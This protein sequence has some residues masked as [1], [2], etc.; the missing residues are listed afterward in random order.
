MQLKTVVQDITTVP[1]AVRD[2]YKQ[3]GDEYVLQT[4]DKDYTK[5]IAEFRDNN[6]ALRKQ[7]ED[8][9]QDMDAKL[10][11]FEGLDEEQLEQMKQAMEQQQ[12]IKDKKLIEEG[13]IE[14]LFQQR[15]E[16]MNADHS[17]QVEG[18]QKQLNKILSERD[19]YRTKLSDTLI[20]NSISQAIGEVAV[21]RKGAMRDILA[22]ARAV[23]KVDDEGSLIPMNGDTVM[24]GPKGDAPLTPQEWGGLLFKE[25]PYL[26]EG[27]VGG[28]A[29]GGHSKGAQGTVE[30]A[31]ADNIGANLE[32]ISTG[33]VTV[34]RGE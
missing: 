8:L 23:W 5:K 30:W 16:R 26:F 31:D 28:G 1:E 22:R 13:K 3:V 21:P 7:V 15:I 9:Q 6:I 14:E 32:A 24:Y 17:G 20:D 27:N 18:L 2:M 25:A 29:Q 34:A 33:K 12:Q 19:S 4:D 11:A 10:K